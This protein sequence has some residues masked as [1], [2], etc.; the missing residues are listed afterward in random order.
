MLP[1]KYVEKILEVSDAEHMDDFKLLDTRMVEEVIT[2]ADLGN[3]PCVSFPVVE[4]VQPGTAF[5]RCRKS[6][7]AA[8]S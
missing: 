5:I 7:A 8:I 2:A 6:H 3:Q 1:G 4:A